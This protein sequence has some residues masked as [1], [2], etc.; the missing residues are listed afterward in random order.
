MEDHHPS[1]HLTG[2]SSP[3]ESTKTP[4]TL[5]TASVEPGRG[6]VNVNRLVSIKGQQGLLYSREELLYSFCLDTCMSQVRMEVVLTMEEILTNR[7]KMP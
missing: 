1:Y 3:S 4:S 6:T 2:Q 5:I 7:I